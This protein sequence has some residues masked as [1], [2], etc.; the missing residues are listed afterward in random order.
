ML[1]DAII[2]G[3]GSM[4]MAAG[5]YLAKR[6]KQ[7]LLVDAGDPPH[8]DG[9]HHGETR[10]I[11]HAYGEGESY[12]EMALQSQALWEELQAETTRTIFKPTGVI[13]IGKEDSDFIQNV[14]SSKERYQ[15]DVERLSPQDIH[16]KWKGFSI[17]EGYIGCYEVNSGVLMSENI[18]RAYRE[19]AVQHGA[20][21]KMNEPVNEIDL[22]ENQVKITTDRHSY[23]GRTLIATPGLYAKEMLSSIGLDLPLE[24]VRKTFSWFHGD[25]NLYAEDRFPAFS[26][27]LD[28]ATYYGFPSVDGA[29]VKIGRHDSGVT[30]DVHQPIEPFGR[31]TEDEQDVSYLAHHYFSSIG[32]HHIGKV[33]TY[34]NTPDGDFIIDRHPIYSHVVFGCG[35]SGHG[36]KFSSVIGETLA[37]LAL[38][39]QPSID[40]TPFAHDRFA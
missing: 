39:E 22:S 6:G 1:Y 13:N 15:L 37:K 33:C 25:E 31:Y 9:S 38:G 11:R 29:G 5:Y 10:I 4:G 24:T 26:F 12:V 7:V 35:F 8:S 2:V 18:I 36:Y 17:P 32:D 27:V 3:A 23:T 14:L 20:I 19:Q 16:A 40:L 28:N 34:T 30:R 21:L